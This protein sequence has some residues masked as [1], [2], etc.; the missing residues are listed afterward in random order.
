MRQKHLSPA[1]YNQANQTFDKLR[2]MWGEIS[3]LD[4]V[5]QLS[6]RLLRTHNLTAGDALQLASAL[7]WCN[8]KPKGRHF[9]CAD[10]KLT[11]AGEAEGFT[12]IYLK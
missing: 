8:E 9:L 11:M 10:E 1:E 7:V 5:R 6:E 4:E 12:M 2:T 3:P